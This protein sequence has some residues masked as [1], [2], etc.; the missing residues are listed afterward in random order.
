MD[1]E[2]QTPGA[3]AKRPPRDFTR[4]LETDGYPPISGGSDPAGYYEK[5]LR[6][7]HPGLSEDEIKTKIK[8]AL[9]D[10][11][12]RDLLEGMEKVDEVMRTRDPDYTYWFDVLFPQRGD[13][14][15]R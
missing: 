15:E 6:R 14:P 11:I 8:E 7:V 5:F 13:K 9:D 12:F 1:R 10:E 3:G 2:T 4:W